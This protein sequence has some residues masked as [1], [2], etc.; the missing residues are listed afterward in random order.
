M[1]QLA[2]RLVARR[3]LAPATR[4]HPSPSSQTGLPQRLVVP[5]GQG[6]LELA[7]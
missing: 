4:R 7:R 2:A 1:E 5:V 3:L 6:L